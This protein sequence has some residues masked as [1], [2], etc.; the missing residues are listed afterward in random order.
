MK[1]TTKPK[2]RIE[3][4]QLTTDEALEYTHESCIYS[5]LSPAFRGNENESINKDSYYAIPFNSSILAILKRIA[6]LYKYKYKKLRFIDVGGGKG[7]IALIALKYFY[8]TI[9]E[10]NPHYIKELKNNGI[11]NVCNIIEH[12]ALTF[13]EYDK[14]NI[15]YSYNIF[16]NSELWRDL[17]HILITQ[18]K[19]KT[20]LILL[21]VVGIFD[22]PEM[23]E[24]INENCY[25][26]NIKY[27]FVKK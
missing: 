14:Y 15:I 18:A 3:F 6:N 17:I 10:N 4:P 5:Y 13:K 24:F 25:L 23:I 19:P 27:V 1:K 8:S 2:K 12:D 22:N 26:T 21:D 7:N 11:S 20:V 16:K 9:L